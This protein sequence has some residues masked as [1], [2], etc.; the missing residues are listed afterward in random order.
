MP[1]LFCFDS[2]VIVI[3]DDVDDVRRREAADIIDHGRRHDPASGKKLARAI[4]ASSAGNN[5]KKK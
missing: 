4:S 3:A 5:A 2:S 1:P